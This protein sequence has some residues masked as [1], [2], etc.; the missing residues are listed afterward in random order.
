MRKIQLSLLLALMLVVFSAATLHAQDT[1]T[2]KYVLW[3]T[4]QLPPY[5]QCADKFQ[6]E[7]PGI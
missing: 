7:N 5:Q 4:N 3:D 1:V 6:Q 2:I